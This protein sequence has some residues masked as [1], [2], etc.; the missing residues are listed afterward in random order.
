[1]ELARRG[2]EFGKMFSEFYPKSA[3]RNFTERSRVSH[4]SSDERKLVPPKK[5]GW[6]EFTK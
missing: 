4:Y 1:M 6:T 5:G 3:I 2:G